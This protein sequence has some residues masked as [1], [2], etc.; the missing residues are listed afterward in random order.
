MTL[1]YIVNKLWHRSLLY[2][3][4]DIVD[5]E[6]SVGPP[7]VERGDAVVLLLPCSVPYLK[8]N[9]DLAEMH[10]LGQ[11]GTCR[12]RNDT[13]EEEGLSQGAK[14]STI[15]QRKKKKKKLDQNK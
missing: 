4:A 13:K 1:S 6:G 12:G 3:V 10:R 11:V 7:V 5:Y 8:T 15:Q 9:G 14:L 2:P